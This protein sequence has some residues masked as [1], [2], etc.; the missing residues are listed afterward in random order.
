[1]IDPNPWIPAPPAAQAIAGPILADRGGENHLT[2]PL[3]RIQECRNRSGSPIVERRNLS[4]HW[5]TAVRGTF[6]QSVRS[7]VGWEPT[8]RKKKAS[9]RRD[10][11]K[12]R[13]SQVIG[14]DRRLIPSGCD[15]RVVSRDGNGDSNCPG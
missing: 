8:G 2:E 5:L 4:D 6:P 7:E 13:E 14:V 12:G 11:R 15:S 9:R 10:A 3:D 1:M